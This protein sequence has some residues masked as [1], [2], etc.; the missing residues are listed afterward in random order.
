MKRTAPTR[1]RASLPVKGTTRKAPAHLSFEADLAL[2]Y[3]TAW[4]LRAG[5]LRVPA[6]ATI[7]RALMVYAG[8]LDGAEPAHEFRAGRS[9]STALPVSEEGQQTP[10]LRLYGADEALPLPSFSVIARGPNAARHA[11]ELT[12]RAEALAAL[13]LQEQRRAA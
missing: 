12:A 7:R 8:H 3:A 1:A 11:A 13:C 2:Q 4:L 9:L 6:S 10:L 5:G